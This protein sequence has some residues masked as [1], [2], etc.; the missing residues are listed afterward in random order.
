M[1]KSPWSGKYPKERNIL[2]LARQSLAGREGLVEAI[3]YRV[4]KVERV[5][6]LLWF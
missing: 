2:N 1:M 6:G 3:L 5:N 4:R